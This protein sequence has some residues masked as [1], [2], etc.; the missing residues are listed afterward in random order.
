MSNVQ[1][2]C[3]D[4]ETLAA[5]VDRALS[6]R[7]MLDVRVHLDKC[8]ACNEMLR[9]VRRVL[10]EVE[11]DRL[12]APR[13]S[14]HRMSW[15]MATAATLAGLT[16]SLLLSHMRLERG[17]VKQL[18]AAI[19]KDQRS[20][21]PRLTGGFPWAPL[22]VNRSGGELTP[23]QMR[24]VGAAGTVLEKAPH[25]PSP[26]IQHAAALAHLLT[27][28]PSVALAILGKLSARS[29]DAS[30]WSDRAA[31]LYADALMRSDTRQLAEALASADTALRLNPGLS[32][33]LF[34]RALIVERLGL[35]EQARRAWQRYLAIESDKEWADEARKHL[36]ALKP[37]EN[38]RDLLDRNYR[39]LA[40][41]PAAAT[42]LARRFPQD[43]RAWGESE[44]LARWG[45][46]WERGDA[47]DAETHLRIASAFGDEL[48]HTFG[49]TMLQSAV[50]AI[51]R[52]RKNDRTV[53]ARA[54]I[55]FR[56]AQR[57]YITRGPSNAENQFENA[58]RGFRREQSPLAFAA[59]YYAANTQYDQGRI[60]EAQSRLERLAAEAPSAFRALH[61]GLDWQLGLTHAARAQWARSMDLLTN[62]LRIFERGGEQAN[63]ATVREI[64]AEVNER[65]GDY[66]NA[67]HLRLAA[68]QSFTGQRRQQNAFLA[69]AR[70]AALNGNWQ[71]SLSLLDLALD[72]PNGPEDELL[73]AMT[74]LLRARMH[75]RLGEHAKAHTDLAAAKAAT[76]RITDGL[77]RERAEASR[78]AVEGE[79]AGSPNEAIALLTKAIEFQTSKGRRMQLPAM[80]LA[81]GRAHEALG[82]FA[83]AAEDFDTGIREQSAQ[84]LS[85]TA[86]ADWLGDPNDGQALFEAGIRLAMARGDSKRAFAYTEEARARQLVD[87]MGAVP[88]LPHG[89]TVI[90]YVA[91][92][93]QLVIFLVTDLQFSARTTA[94]SSTTLTLA[95]ARLANSA[96]SRDATGFRRAAADLYDLLI[97]PVQTDIAA[98]N[99]IAFVPDATLAAVPFSALVQPDG[100]YLLEQHE[101]VIA[102]SVATYARSERQRRPHQEV[103]R[104]LLV[105]GSPSYDGKVFTLLPG[106]QRE[107]AAVAAAYGQTDAL[108]P[109]AMDWTDFERHAARA[110]VIHFAGHAF[111]PEDRANGA[112]VTSRIDGSPKRIDTCEIAA[113]KLPH[114]RVVV[115]AGCSTARA[116]ATGNDRRMSISDAF[117]AADVPSVVATLWSIDDASS[118]EF[119]PALHRRLAEGFSPSAAVRATQLEWLQ[120]RESSLLWA[121]VQTFGS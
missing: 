79:L 28:R 110:D 48:A 72:L 25:N 108:N 105:P 3:P 107:A 1:R 18:V 5:Y 102:T 9:D 43:A 116:S 21:E 7:E 60:D 100:H 29:G 80:Y 39:E 119:F 104:L 74:L 84:R 16:F 59:E 50:G 8:D 90:E 46:A 81:R 78:L 17:P 33:A 89:H 82:R 49:E 87:V 109:I 36:L 24:L 63:A 53:L 54:H 26:D 96:T 2:P 69:A 70:N 61:A 86:A 56:D 76:D 31:A 73:N 103:P 12:A 42:S 91:L 40:R 62:S 68:F 35:R 65:I 85:V 6:R 57:L 92:P 88:S 38:F 11:R 115:L 27:G 97:R 118:A 117:L 51:T 112:L 77:L 32:E 41:D 45:A 95:V 52:T 94:T 99:K 106:V 30:V 55:A 111:F 34:N 120:R 23:A 19:P 93:D 121:A 66:S 114:T 67:Q 47:A 75:A 14:R 83:A 58:A 71:L 37:E 15:F 22:Q 13:R 98:G 10:D 101:I 113:M 44:L 4:L 20:L 64:L